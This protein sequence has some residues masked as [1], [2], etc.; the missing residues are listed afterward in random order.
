VS[1][2][3]R[4]NELIDAWLREEQQ[5]FSGWDF[6]YLKGRVTQEQPPWSY[7]SRAAALLRGSSSVVDLGTAGG[8]RLL[9]MREHWPGK[10]TVTEE[11]PPNLALARERLEPLGVRVVDARLTD[12]DPLPFESAEFDLVL[13]RHSAF[14]AAEVGRVLAPGGTFLT[15]QVHG[16]STEDLA[17]AF[18]AQ[19]LWP[20]STPD[21][22]LPRLAAAGLE[23]VD[24]EEWSGKVVFKDVG[25]MVYQ[26][27]AVPWQVQ[28]FSVATHRDYLLRL[29]ARLD[30]GHE[31]AFTTRLYLIEARQP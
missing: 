18:D 23:I 4:E 11:Y 5:P 31:L 27:K 28:G 10:V 30:A 14:N 20:D 29:Q 7:A 12:Y 13:N 1:T 6:A 9:A 8:E 26:L 15:Q 21:K 24:T 17:A 19:L 16:R 25:A 3:T 2:A 22:Y